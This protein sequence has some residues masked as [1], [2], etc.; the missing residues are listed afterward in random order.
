MVD[1]S[2]M[3]RA[4]GDQSPTV[5]P[6]HHHSKSEQS[7]KGGCW[8]RTLWKKDAREW[9]MF[10]EY[11]KRSEDSERGSLCMPEVAVVVLSRDEIIK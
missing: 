9:L 11:D 6:F 5:F 4:R 8:G 10:A 3:D 2:E 7:A 1:A